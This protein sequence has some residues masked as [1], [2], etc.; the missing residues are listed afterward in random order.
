MEWIRSEYIV[1]RRPNCLISMRGFTNCITG[2][3]GTTLN[4]LY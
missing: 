1:H 2:D 4:E 3:N